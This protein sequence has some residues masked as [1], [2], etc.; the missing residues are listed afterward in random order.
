LA[1]TLADCVVEGY[2]IARAEE[3]A[4]P[5]LPLLLLPGVYP[6]L[7]GGPEQTAGGLDLSQPRGDEVLLPSDPF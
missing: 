4:Q 6:V 5:A 2:E 1:S 3:A 7:G